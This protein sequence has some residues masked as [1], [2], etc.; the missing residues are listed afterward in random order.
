[1]ICRN[2]TFVRKG[3]IFWSG[4]KIRLPL[5]RDQEIQIGILE[6]EALAEMKIGE[7][8]LEEI[9]A[10]AQ[11]DLMPDKILKPTFL[12]CFEQQRHQHIADG[13]GSRTGNTRRDIGYAVMD[14]AVF[15]DDGL[16]VGGDPGGL[17]TAAAVDADVND[18]RAGAH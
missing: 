15:V 6:V 1:M 9:D 17:E 16:F 10:A 3:S 12:S 2:M 4:S 13:M 7:C 14:D 5:T 11:M 18:D 8:A